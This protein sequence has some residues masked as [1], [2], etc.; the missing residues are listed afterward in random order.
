MELRIFKYFGILEL[1]PDYFDILRQMSS[2]KLEISV[3]STVFQSY[4]LET[5]WLEFAMPSENHYI[6]NLISYS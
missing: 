2:A 1:K 4:L 6:N 3:S 5:G